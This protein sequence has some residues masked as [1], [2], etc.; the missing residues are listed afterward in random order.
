[1]KLGVIISNDWELYG[2]GSGDF[3]DDQYRLTEELLE[4]CENHGA[5]LTLMA[6]VGQ[7]WAHQKISRTEGWALDVVTSW[8]NQLIDTVKRQHDVQLHLHP[9]WIGPITFTNGKWQLD[10]RYLVFSGLSEREQ[11]GV[12]RSGKQYLDNLLRPVKP[13]YSCI[14]FRAGGSTTKPYKNI[15]QS[16][17][18]VGILSDTSVIK[19]CFEHGQCDYRRAYSNY[20]PWFVEPSDIMSQGQTNTG[21]L[22]IPIYSVPITDSPVL[23]KTYLPHFVYRYNFGL[24]LPKRERDWVKLRNKNI[25]ERYSLLQRPTIRN[26]ATNV[27]WIISQ[28]ISRNSL[29]LAYD[30]LPASVFIYMLHRLAE[31]IE[32]RGKHGKE[33]VFPVMAFGHVKGMTTCDNINLIFEKIKGEFGDKVVFWTYSD[34]VRYWMDNFVDIK[35]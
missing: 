33:F 4:V 27:K 31:K 35:E 25:L 10:S 29:R 26:N 12:L 30:F 34:A 21:I 1:M 8:E 5:K 14:G 24:A 28:I 16:L 17:L 22:E 13:E 23:R 18:N 15:V 6:E 3:Y 2:D 7:Q 20:E 11:E 9:Q 32:R 19:G